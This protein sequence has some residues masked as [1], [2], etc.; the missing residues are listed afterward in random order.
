MNKVIEKAQRAAELAKAHLELAN[1]IDALREEVQWASGTNKDHPLAVRVFAVKGFG[2][3][4]KLTEEE[5]KRILTDLLE[6]L[7]EEL[8]QSQK[9][10]EALFEPDKPATVGR[11]IRTNVAGNKEDVTEARTLLNGVWIP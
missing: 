4:F 7:Q 3:E 1:R 8:A 11:V 10:L 6:T 9:E 2:G 5:Y